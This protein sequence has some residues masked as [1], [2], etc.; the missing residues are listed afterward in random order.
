MLALI[1]RLVLCLGMWAQSAAAAAPPES[2]SE[3]MLSEQK[4][5]CECLSSV[6]SP[7]WW[8]SYN[9]ALYFQPRN[10]AQAKQLEAMRAARSKYVALTNQDTRHELTARL[11]AE[12]RVGENWRG[13]LLLPLSATN[14]TLTPTLDRTARVIPRYKLLQS[15]GGGDALIQDDASTY[16]V[17]NFGRGTDDAACTNALLIKEGVKAYS[18]GESF[19]MVEAFSDVALNKEET[20]VLNRVAAAFQKEAAALGQEIANLRLKPEFESYQAR[21]NDSSPYMEFLLARAYLE[22][23]GTDKNEQLGL[24][25]M[26]RAAKNGSGDAQSYLEALG[27]KPH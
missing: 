10:E 26:N 5:F 27:R 8:L 22:G 24:E 9:G 3:Q 20:A 17:M 2:L 19:K 14:Q 11:I 1:G 13:R 6:Y 12:S 18:A 23:K 21:A 25:W 7:T 4:H 15:L 16:F